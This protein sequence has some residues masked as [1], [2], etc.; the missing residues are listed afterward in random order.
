M[1]E[2]G[3]IV[4]RFDGPLTISQ[5]Y[6]IGNRLIDNFYTVSFKLMEVFD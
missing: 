2:S 4:A 3:T 6:S 5:T 1:N